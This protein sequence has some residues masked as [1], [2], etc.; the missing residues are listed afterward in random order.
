MENPIKMD[1]LG[2]PLKFDCWKTG[3]A[4]FSGVLLLA[5]GRVYPR[6]DKTSFRH[7]DKFQRNDQRK[8]SEIERTHYAL[9]KVC[10][11]S[12]KNMLFCGESM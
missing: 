10:F 11:S 4:I 2:V 8:N 7:S 3:F 9:V 1:D 5:S 6:L 12:G